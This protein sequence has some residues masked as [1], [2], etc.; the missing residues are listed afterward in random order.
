MVFTKT[1]SDQIRASVI[2]NRM[3]DVTER[4]VKYYLIKT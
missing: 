4:R 2:R 1:M 3:N